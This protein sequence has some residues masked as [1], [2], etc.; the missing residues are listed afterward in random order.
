[1]QSLGL[2]LDKVKNNTIHFNRNP[3][4]R[5]KPDDVYECGENFALSG[6]ELSQRCTYRVHPDRDRTHA[7]GAHHAHPGTG[8]A[9]AGA[10]PPRRGYGRMAPGIGILLPRRR[11][12]AGSREFSRSQLIA[13]SGPV[14]VVADEAGESVAR[15]PTTLLCV[16]IPGINFEY[17]E[18]DKKKFIQMPENVPNM[19][20]LARMQC[21]WHHTMRLFQDAKVTHPVCGGGSLSNLLP[22]P[23]CA[24]GCGAFAGDVNAVPIAYA[25][26][27]CQVL[28]MNDYGMQTVFVSLVD[29]EHFKAFSHA[30]ERYKD[31]VRCTVVLTRS[32]GMLGLARHL[33]Q[34]GLRSGFLNP[35]DAQAVRKGAIGMYWHGYDI[36]LEEPWNNWT[37]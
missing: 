12:V 17:G 6:N 29:P 33:S 37:I 32:H 16:S 8:H 34:K 2:R 7:V 28:T 18:E 15:T 24:I 4:K 11:R 35:S 3:K 26:Q 5:I 9:L 23:L 19:A 10:V 21:I 30:L 13:V 1:M 14:Y 20:G 25:L 31:M 36:A 27:L 22:V